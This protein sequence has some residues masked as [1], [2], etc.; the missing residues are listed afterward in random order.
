MHGPT[1]TVWANLTPFSIQRLSGWFIGGPLNRDSLAVVKCVIA[2]MLRRGGLKLEG[3]FR[4]AGSLVAQR[5]LQRWF[6]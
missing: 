2:G 4:V 5:A 6:E 3:I 1:F